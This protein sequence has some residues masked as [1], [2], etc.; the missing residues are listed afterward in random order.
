MLQPIREVTKEWT[1]MQETVECVICGNALIY[2]TFDR[3]S[4][5]KC[6][7]VKPISQQPISWEPEAFTPELIA[8]IQQCNADSTP[9]NW[10]KWAEEV[11]ILN[12]LNENNFEEGNDVEELDDDIDGTLKDAEDSA[13]NLDEALEAEITAAL[14]AEGGFDE[15]TELDPDERYV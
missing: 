1:M 7:A 13:D 5:L 14:A 3:Q 10:S 4:H 2:L 15:D 11:A 6:W 12:Q 9:A 8:A